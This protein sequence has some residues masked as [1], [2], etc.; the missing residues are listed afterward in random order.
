VKRCDLCSAEFTPSRF[1]GTRQRFCSD[2]CSKKAAPSYNRGRRNEWTSRDCAHCGQT[3]QRASKTAGSQ[4]YCGKTCRLAAASAR[5]GSQ[6]W[7][8]IARRYG[9]TPDFVEALFEVQG[10]CCAICRRPLDG[11]KLDL[12]APQVDH[13]HET[14]LVRG[15]LCRACNTGLGMLGDSV[16]TLR[17]ALTY[18]LASRPATAELAD[19]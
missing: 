2:K 7:K 12:T 6:R 17:A 10:G 19:V 5:E 9:V 3:F 11:E 18:L 1:T 4:R 15:I 8:H 14:G 16:E 13:D